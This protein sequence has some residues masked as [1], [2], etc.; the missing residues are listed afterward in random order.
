MVEKLLLIGDGCRGGF[1]VNVQSYK[2]STALAA[3]P[4]PVRLDVFICVDLISRPTAHLPYSVQAP[5]K[6]HTVAFVGEFIECRVSSYA[7]V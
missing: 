7:C 3:Q 5:V 1:C 2:N 6:N 4:G